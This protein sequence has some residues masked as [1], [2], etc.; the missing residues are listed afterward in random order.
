MLSAVRR[1]GDRELSAQFGELFKLLQCLSASR[2][3]LQRFMRW[4]GCSDTRNSEEALEKAVKKPHSRLPRR[5]SGILQPFA[6][7]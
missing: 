2:R 6:K 3:I 5:L 1:A 7:M 4:P